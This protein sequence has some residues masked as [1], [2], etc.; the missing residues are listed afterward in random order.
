[1]RLTGTALMLLVFSTNKSTTVSA[2]KL[3]KRPA[4]RLPNKNLSAGKPTV[5]QDRD[6]S[7]LP[8]DGNTDD[9]KWVAFAKVPSADSGFS[10]D[11]PETIPF[12]GSGDSKNKRGEED[13]VTVPPKASA[14]EDARKDDVVS[15]AAARQPSLP[16]SDSSFLRPARP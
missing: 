10:T 2:P 6:R 7:G 14:D 8:P 9:N 15:L 13:G 3:V 4:V 11:T 1:M 16:H 12:S 5:P